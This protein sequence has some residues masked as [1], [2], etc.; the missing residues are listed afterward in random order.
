M[1]L[2]SLGVDNHIVQVD[3][4]VCEVQLPQAILHEVLECCWSITQ[5][6]GHVQKLV[7]AHAAH[8]KGSVLSGLLSHLNLPEPTLQVHTRK[9]SGTHHALHGLLHTRQG[10]GVL[11]GS[12]VQAVEVDTKPER[13]ILLPHQYHSI[14]P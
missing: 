1:F 6:A 10:I 3:Q 8:C 5:T 4:G 2:F 12:G 11:L 9:V 7:N 14:T 13:P